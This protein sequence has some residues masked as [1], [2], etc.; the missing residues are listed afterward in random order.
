MKGKV[1]TLREFERMRIRYYDLD[2]S[3]SSIMEDYEIETDDDF[4]DW[5]NNYHGEDE[6][7]AFLKRYSKL[8]KL[9]AGVDDV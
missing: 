4:Y 1:P 7:E 3:Y 5:W 8:G 2:H 6:I 9:L